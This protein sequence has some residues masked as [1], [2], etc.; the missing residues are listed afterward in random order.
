MAMRLCG[1]AAIAWTV[2]TATIM[3]ILVFGLSGQLARSLE[4][5]RPGGFDGTFAGRATCDLAEPAR[6]SALL[7][8][9]HPDMIVN[10]AAYTQV[11][12]AEEEP[13]LAHR[14]NGE[15]VADM[16]RYVAAN[17]ARLIHISTDFVFDGSKSE[18]YQPGD[19]TGP[20]GK[21][22]DS[23][24]AGETAALQ[25]APENTMIIRTAWVYSEH[26][27]N[28]VKTMLRLMRE[29][30]QLGVVDDQR[31]APTYARGLAEVIWQIVTQDLFRPGIYHWTDSGNI[32]WHDFAV[33]IQQEGASRGLLDTL[34]PVN[35]IATE[36]YP[37]PAARP[38]YSV[39]D[40]GKLAELLGIEPAPWRD[41]LR[42]MLE[43][44]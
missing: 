7:D 22:G 37:T 28:F 8:E 39:L 36:A 18:P 10:A 27:N 33:A 20:L 25:R 34:I 14:I 17:D 31:G 3:R 40:T 21:Y 15:A 12:R 5:T 11:D 42:K 38:A 23:K 41:N 44:L 19:T 2:A 4:D 32:T 29:R 35:P 6:V 24:L 43:R 13:E 26:G 30:D 1:S 9:R 16:A